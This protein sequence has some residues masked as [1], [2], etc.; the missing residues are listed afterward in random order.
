MNYRKAQNK[1]LD[2]LAALFDKY[3]VFYRKEAD[4]D[5]AKDFIAERISSNDSEIFVAENTESQLVGFVQLY[6]LF[7]STRMEKL[8]LLNDLFVDPDNRGKG[9]SIGLINKA[10]ELVKTSDACGMFLETEKSNLIGNNLYPKTGFELNKG[11]NFYEW[12]IQ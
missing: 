11:A 4:I 1:D 3:R 12:S 8:W 10:K 2:N 9:I 5:G 6:P 7:S